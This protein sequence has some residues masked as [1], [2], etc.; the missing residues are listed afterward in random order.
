M[1]D[2]LYMETK[3]LTTCADNR[4]VHWKVCWKFPR[5]YGVIL[6]FFIVF[7]N[8]KKIVAQGPYRRW[9]AIGSS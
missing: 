5:S 2:T 1:Q 3:A 4:D 6:P 9:D 8:K 7:I